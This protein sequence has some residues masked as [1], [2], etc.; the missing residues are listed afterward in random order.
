[1]ADE[2][3]HCTSCGKGLDADSRFCKSCGTAVSKPTECGDCGAGLDS[4][5][6]FCRLCGKPVPGAEPTASRAAADPV[7]VAA[8]VAPVLS[9]EDVAPARPRRQEPPPPVDNKSA[10]WVGVA[11]VVLAFGW[12]IAKKDSMPVGSAP[13]TAKV[14]APA[15]AAASAAAC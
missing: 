11:V 13:T 6:A 15:A 9:P 12:L 10:V 8:A 5:A 4:D 7:P 3:M 2:T 1:M 14:G